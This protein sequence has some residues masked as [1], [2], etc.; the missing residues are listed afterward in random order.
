MELHEIDS[1]VKQWLK[2]IK[3]HLFNNPLT[4]LSFSTKKN[5]RDLVTP[6]DHAVEK[7]LR[8]NI[9]KN[10]PDP[11]IIGEES[12]NVKLDTEKKLLKSVKCI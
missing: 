10:F 8:D 5:Y 3:G 7:Y 6:I 4:D 12:S 2:Y 11:C 1:L 9:C